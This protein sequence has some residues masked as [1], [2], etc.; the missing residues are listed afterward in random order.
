MKILAKDFI[1]REALEAH[2]TTLVPRT[3]ESKSDFEIEGTMAE[4][5][6]L[7]LSPG[8]VCW[9]VMA[10]ATDVEEVDEDK[11]VTQSNVEKVERGKIFKPEEEQKVDINNSVER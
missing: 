1:T 2:I 4:L 8:Q 7:H 9:G 10:K 6:T 5:K 3:A 11:K